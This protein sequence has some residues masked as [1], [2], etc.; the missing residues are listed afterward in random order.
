MDETVVAN[1]PA[2]AGRVVIVV[3]PPVNETDEEEVDKAIEGDAGTVIDFI[4][5]ADTGVP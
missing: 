3:I 2:V 1:A 5:I 4:I